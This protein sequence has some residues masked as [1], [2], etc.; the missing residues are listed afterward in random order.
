[1]NNSS[2][3][4][5][6]KE[7]LLL[8]ITNYLVNLKHIKYITEMYCITKGVTHLYLEE[9]ETSKLLNESFQQICEKTKQI[10]LKIKEL[11]QCM[12]NCIT[13]INYENKTRK[14]K[15]EHKQLIPKKR[16]KICC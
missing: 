4:T 8:K 1:M 3:D 9:E 7:L 2:S 13:S 12:K 10:L 6:N 16:Q 14:R 5:M 15:R 11:K